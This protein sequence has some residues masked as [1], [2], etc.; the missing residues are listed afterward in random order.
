MRRPNVHQYFVYLMSNEWETALYT[1]V[2]N[3]IKRRVWQHKN[4]T[5]DGFTK[6]YSCNRLVH[7]ETYQ[8]INDAIAR[9][10]QIKGW[11]RA[12]KNVLI[13]ENN[14]KWNDLSAEWDERS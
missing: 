12:K 9:E 4:G 13:K 3:D 10:K 11:S 1:G 5:F 2:T 6:R 14:P 8:D 7:V